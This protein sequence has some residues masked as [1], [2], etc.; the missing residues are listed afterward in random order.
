MDQED[1][2]YF[3]MLLED[4]L[5][6]LGRK[7]GLTLN[8]LLVDDRHLPDPLDRA[9]SD[10]VVSMSLRIRDRESKLIRK[11]IKALSNID[12]GNFGICEQCGRDI[13]IQRMKVRPVTTLC[14]KCKT[15]MELAEK[16]RGD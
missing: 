16:N 3:R 10:T 15:K 11:I 4:Q 12:S 8:E 14:I 13:A 6:E 9:T 5:M 1:I 7:A 2:D